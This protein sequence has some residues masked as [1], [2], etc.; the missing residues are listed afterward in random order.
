MLLHRYLTV[1]LLCSSTAPRVSW[2]TLNRLLNTA[3]V[4]VLLWSRVLHPLLGT[5]ASAVC[6]AARALCNAPV[7]GQVI[8]AVSSGVGGGFCHKV[9]AWVP[10]VIVSSLTAGELSPISQSV[11]LAVAMVLSLLADTVRNKA[12]KVDTAQPKEV[13]KYYMFIW[14]IFYSCYFLLPLLRL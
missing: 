1:G 7:S 8:R 6:D 10:S 3:A 5:L 11:R 12:L 4:G 9:V 13:F 2:G 14:N